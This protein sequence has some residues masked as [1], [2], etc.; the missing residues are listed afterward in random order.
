MEIILDSY[1]V[2][3]LTTINV[4][5]FVSLVDGV[6]QLD[7]KGLIKAQQL[8]SRI[9]LRMTLVELELPHWNEVQERDR[10]VGTSMT[11]WQDAIAKL[12]YTDKEEELLL[13]LLRGVSRKE[14]DRYA[15]ELRISTPLLATTVKP[16]GTLSQVAGGVSSGLHMSH[17]PFYVRRI[18]INSNDPLVKVALDLGW[19]IHAEVGTLGF[20]EEADLA[21]PEAINEA[22]TLVI[23][24]P[25]NSGSKRTK[26]DVS[27]EEQFA[28][29]FRFQKHYTEHNSSNT[30]TVKPGEWEKAEEI[31]F[32]NCDDFVGVSFLSHD[33]GTYK[34]APYEAISEEEYHERKNSMTPFDVSLL[35]KYEES[36]TEA[37]LDDMESCESGI[38]P[39]R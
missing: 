5:K 29:Y 12:D 21:T 16:E 17:S 23:D 8:S 10:L 30:I 26:D 27:V 38:C 28:T 36:E 9:G 20:M 33:G 25:V 14:V 15:K 32:E 19:K 37:D 7:V 24:F 31:V 22:R 13:Q 11:G 4:D 35:R 18:R 2:C 39:I 3:N 34:L 1:G 6:Y